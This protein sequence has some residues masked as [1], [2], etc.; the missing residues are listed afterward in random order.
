MNLHAKKWL[1]TKKNG[2]KR[3]KMV[4]NEKKRPGAEKNGSELKKMARKGKKWPGTGKNELYREKMVRT[5]KII[6]YTGRGNHAP[7]LTKINKLQIIPN[8]PYVLSVK[9]G[10]GSPRP[11]TMNIG[12]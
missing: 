1:G 7:T 11:S 2:L 4:G 3:K 8:A 6:K 5:E 12:H 9:V 10:A